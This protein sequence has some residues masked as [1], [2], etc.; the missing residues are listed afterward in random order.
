MRSH[1]IEELEA[2]RTNFLA[3]G[4]LVLE[5]VNNAIQSIRRADGVTF[6]HAKELEAK[7]NASTR[8]VYDQALR[9]LT[10][11]APVAS[12]ARLIAGV[13]ESIVDLE[14]I[15]DYALD[16][17]EMALAA[18]RR[19]NAQVVGEV[20]GIAERVREM[21]VSALDAWRHIDREKGLS[22]R[23]NETFIR[24]DCNAITEK[25]YQ[26]TQTPGD[27]QI[28]VD[29]VLITRYLARIVRHAIA[30]AEQA[31]AASPTGR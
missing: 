20:A 17:S 28:Y 14:E 4:D 21:L 9:I 16:V 6:E 26:L 11:Q 8:S 31:A 2:L 13:I 22:V 30:I 12:D 3:M 10:L 15:G 25:L 29:M 27:T 5:S 24:S 23:P 7:I 18:A 19:A 1:F